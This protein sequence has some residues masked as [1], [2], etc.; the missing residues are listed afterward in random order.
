MN[1]LVVLAGS[2]IASGISGAISSGQQRR[3]AEYA[4]AQSRENAEIQRSLWKDQLREGPARQIAGMKAAGLNPAML[5]G[6]MP[7]TPA[8]SSSP[9]SPVGA[10]PVKFDPVGDMLDAQRVENETKLADAQAKL[11]KEQAGDQ[12]WKNTPGYRDRVLRGMDQN[13]NESVSREAENYSNV[14]LNDQKFNESVQ[15]EA[16]L[17]KKCGV[18]DSEIAKNMGDYTKSVYQCA[19]ILQNMK[20]SESR[21]VLNKA[22][23]KCQNS[24]S[25]LYDAAKK[26][27][28]ITNEMLEKQKYDLERTITARDAVMVP[29]VD[30]EGNPT[31]HYRSYWGNQAALE[32]N[33]AAIANITSQ[34]ELNMLMTLTPEERQKYLMDKDIVHAGA[35]VLGAAGSVM[36]GSAALQNAGKPPKQTTFNFGF[37]GHQQ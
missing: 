11:L 12:S 18:A 1:P 5:Q 6:G 29:A 8:L 30:G 10:N 13:I 20:E 19:E 25:G 37:P 17:L 28:L 22:T 27:Q 35:A 16:L 26:G 23:A 36:S 9:G 4:S 24:L 3:A 31:G 33:A 15:N 14:H 7:G 32:A 2:A 21:I 34:Y